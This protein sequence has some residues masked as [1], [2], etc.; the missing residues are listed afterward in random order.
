[1]ASDLE[2]I[3][4][5]SFLTWKRN[6]SIGVPFLFS[7]MINSL[8]IVFYIVVM[9]LLINPLQ[10]NPNWIFLLLGMLLFIPLLFI[11]SLISSF[12]YAGAIGMSKKAVET[13]KTS[14]DDMVEYGRKKFI[15]LFLTELLILLFM[16]VIGFMVLLIQ[17]L[18]RGE[19]ITI[20][21][22][23]VGIVFAV[24]PF[25]VVISDLGVID[26]LKKGYGFFMNNKFRVILL[27]VFTRY[28]TQFIGYG[29]MLIGV[30]ILSLAI[31][32]IP[33]PSDMSPQSWIPLIKPISIT[34]GIAF[35]I[36]FII[37]LSISALIISPLTTIFWSGLYLDKNREQQNDGIH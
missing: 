9:Y 8:F 32:V 4:R 3:L 31:P 6:L 28:L 23:I 24:V 19:F 34:L 29:V 11:M 20:F 5:S 26:G 33:L 36:F 12:F 15:T 14:L 35:I 7:S 17:M 22:T 13:G 30:V 2:D 25:A 16:M 27:W 21:I 37:Y 1:M 10:P 18:F